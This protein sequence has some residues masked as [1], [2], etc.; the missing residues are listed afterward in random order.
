MTAKSVH[1]TSQ[2]L[3]GVILGLIFSISMYPHEMCLA[4][5]GWY[6]TAIA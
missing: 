5:Y 3:D 2:T 6:A 4:L 1:G